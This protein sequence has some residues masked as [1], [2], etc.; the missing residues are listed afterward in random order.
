MRDGML[1]R[2]PIYRWRDS[3]LRASFIG[4]PETEWWPVLPGQLGGLRTRGA[5][6]GPRSRCLGSHAVPGL[7]P[8]SPRSAWSSSQGASSCP[9]HSVSGWSCFSRGGVCCTI[10]PCSNLEISMVVTHDRY[11]GLP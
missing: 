6:L 10:I 7:P 5:Q 11:H 8:S 1:L 9:F 2:P 4:F 3:V